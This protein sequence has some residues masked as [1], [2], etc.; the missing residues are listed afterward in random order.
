MA[1]HA[2]IAPSSLALT[3]ACEASVQ[4]QAAI[5]ELPDSEEQFE[6]KV[7]H[8]V[9]LLTAAGAPYPVGHEFTY[10]GRQCT[11]DVDMF[12][13]ARMYVAALGGSHNTLRLEDGVRC[14]AIHPTACYGTPDAFRY[15]PDGTGPRGMPVLRVGDYKY[16]HRFV[17]VFENYQLIA[18]AFGVI[19]R[20]N[21][22]SLGDA[23]ILELILV[24]PR[25]YHVE[26][27][28]RKWRTTVGECRALVAKAAAKAEAA[29]APNPIAS[30]GTHCGD[31]RARHVCTTLRHAVANV[32]DYSTVG[33]LS[34]LDHIAMGQELRILDDAA[35]RLDA[36]RTGLAAQVEAAIRAGQAVPFYKMAPG[37]SNLAWPEGMSEAEIAA[38]G[39][40]LG[41]SV[42]K[43]LQV[44]TPRQAIDAG[45]EEAVVMQFA[46][47]PAGAMKLTRESTT[48]VRKAFSNGVSST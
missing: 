24:Q 22:E 10:E 25:A 5:P 21:L 47:R 7:A 15:L 20:L 11:V 46:S 19:E 28:V 29:L 3:V 1:A 17:E 6:G 31:C 43:P 36:R 48:A 34:P 41:V 39:D 42:R 16:G 4:L 27:P 44:Y 30:T 2:L 32:V 9:A 23:L 37:R 38:M 26:G 14:T 12:N 13:G 8:A 33:E 45:I 40:L 18:Y 35:A